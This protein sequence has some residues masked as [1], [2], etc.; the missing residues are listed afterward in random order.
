VVQC[1]PY[2]PKTKMWKELSFREWSLRCV[3]LRAYLRTSLCSNL[4]LSFCH[5][6]WYIYPLHCGFLIRTAGKIWHRQYIKK[7][8]HLPMCTEASPA[9]IR[10]RKPDCP[11]FIAVRSIQHWL[12]YPLT[13]LRQC[14]EVVFSAAEAQKQAEVYLRAQVT[15]CRRHDTA[16]VTMY[17]SNIA[18]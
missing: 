18:N 8:L 4:P 6:F 5:R 14:T 15:S 2:I 7:Q 12:L 10:Q 16:I 1:L 3:P 17:A 11:H 9:A 13:T